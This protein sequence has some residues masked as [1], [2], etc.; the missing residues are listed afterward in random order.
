MSPGRAQR[1]QAARTVS[2]MIARAGEAGGHLARRSRARWDHRVM[3]EMYLSQICDCGPA[4]RAPADSPR[5]R[6]GPNATVAAWRSRRREEVADVAVSAGAHVRVPVVRGTSSGAR[7][8]GVTRR[9]CDEDGGASGAGV[10]FGFRHWALSTRSTFSNMG[11]QW[12][13]EILA[14]SR[15]A[16]ASCAAP[17]FPGH[18]YRARAEGARSTQTA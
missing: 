4:R 3:A 11:V 16:S 7:R 1:A 2:D 6:S 17:S 13:L 18:D 10:Q 12:Q 9:P 8:T 5:T 14:S 15:H